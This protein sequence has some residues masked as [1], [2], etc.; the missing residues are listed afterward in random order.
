MIKA[1][2]IS[3]V[4]ISMAILLFVVLVVWGIYTAMNS[5]AGYTL[6]QSNALELVETDAAD[7]DS[8]STASA[9]GYSNGIGA[10][11]STSSDSSDSEA[12]Q[13]TDSVN[14]DNAPLSNSSDSSTGSSSSSSSEGSTS[15]GDGSMN[16]SIPSPAPAEPQKTYH[17]AWDEWVEEGHWENVSVPATYGSRAVFGSVCNECGANIS[18]AA[19]AHLKETHHSGYREDVVGSEQYE[20]TP[21]RTEQ[22]WVDTSHWVHHLGYWD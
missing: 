2:K 10:K 4:I 22:V 9:S 14:T 15:N 6:S 21:A 19:M 5:A 13:S 16:S 12:G 8:D 7:G 1:L 3:R 17:P 11:S 20:V 18:G